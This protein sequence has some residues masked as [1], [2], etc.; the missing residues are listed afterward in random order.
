MELGLR[1]LTPND[2]MELFKLFDKAGDGEIEYQEFIVAV[3]GHLNKRRRKFVHMAFKIMDKDGSGELDYNDLVDTYNAKKHPDVISRKRTEREVLE[4]FLAGF[5]VG[6]EKDGK[7]T[8][9][10]WENYYAAVSANVDSDDYF[11]LMMRNAWHISGGEGQ[12]AN[13]SNRRVLVTHADGRQTVEEV[14]NDIGIDK[15]NGKA[16]SHNIK[17]Q[18]MNPDKIEF[19]SGDKPDQK[20]QGARGGPKLSSSNRAIATGAR[21]SQ[22]GGGGSAVAEKPMSNTAQVAYLKMKEAL[23]ARGAKGI[24]G[25]GR[26]FRQMDDDGSKSLDKGE[27]SKGMLELGI[28]LTPSEINALFN[29][30]DPDRSGT[31]DYEEFLVILRGEMSP[32]RKDLVSQA[33]NILDKDGNGRIEYDDIIDTYNAKK[34]PD[35]LAGTRTEKDILSEFLATFDVGGE[36]DGIVT[37]KEFENYYENISSTIENDAY[38]ELMIRNAWHISGGVGQAAN[39]SNRRVLVT[40]AD[41]RQTV[42]EIKNDIRIAKKDEAAMKNNLSS[43]GIKADKIEFT[44]GDKPDEKK[45]KKG[46][47]P[48]Q[49]RGSAPGSGRNSARG[50]GSGPSSAREPPRPGQPRQQQRTEPPQ[51]DIGD[52]TLGGAWDDDAE[53][54]APVKYK[55]GAAPTRGGNAQSAQTR[56][57]Y[58]A[59]TQPQ[60]QARN[61]Y[62]AQTQPQAQARNPY[63]AQTQPQ[64]QAPQGRQSRTPSNGSVNAAQLRGAPAQAAPEQAPAQPAQIPDLSPEETQAEMKA[65]KT[66][67]IALYNGNHFSA[68]LEKFS[69]AYELMH[70]VFPRHGECTKLQNSIKS[71]SKNIASGRDIEVQDE[72]EEY[73]STGNLACDKLKDALIA[74]GAKGICGL[75]KKFRIIDDDGNGTLNQNEF[76]KLLKL[77]KIDM[78]THEVMSLF[79]FFDKDGSGTISFDE[80]LTAITGVMNKR[81]KALVVMAFNIMDKDGN[82]VLDVDDVVDSYNAKMHPEVING[83]KT[84]KAVLAEFLDT[85]DV[86]GVK[87][88][89]VSLLEFMNYYSAVSASI[90]NDDYF[91]LMMRNA[92]HI[93]GGEGQCANT[94]NRRVLVT[95]ADGRQTVE[96]V[97]NDIRIAKKD[98]AAM[99]NNL[100]SQ[101]IKADKIEFTYGDKPDEKKDKKNPFQVMGS[102]INQGSYQ[103]GAARPSSSSATYRRK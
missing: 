91:E 86:G 77:V 46:A 97:Q 33:F 38:F 76:R 65:L 3:R 44:Y 62:A 47:P 57:P 13:T 20:G 64:A 11:E 26:R 1:G 60:A 85:F 51:V 24:C 96:E 34:H 48:V 56:N 30:M 16:I 22:Q 75:S 67:A 69:L 31:I 45:D 10:E 98:E 39:S 18:G 88:G 79:A 83:N 90:D 74:R 93:S 81:R 63:A 25:L 72:E 28:G 54:P 53:S 55:A 9:Q 73:L 40:H 82:G 41:G 32:M 19:T 52:L 103:Q 78:P 29:Y 89:T 23:I 71:C 7:V 84:E 50:S 102:G 8:L 5:D 43:Q 12:C 6:G 27:F 87:D 2:I 99:K 80:F 36:K 100:S 14:Q 37:A 61:P 21:G 70:R 59:Q 42:E 58:A 15:S 4:E 49:M 101:G 95:H 17:N 94:S 66:A 35:V 68:A 92:W